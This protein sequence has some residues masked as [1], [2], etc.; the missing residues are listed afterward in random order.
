MDMTRWPTPKLDWLYSL[1]PKM[2]KLYSISN[3]DV[4]VVLSQDTLGD[5]CWKGDLNA[6]GDPR[7][8][9]ASRNQRGGGREMWAAEQRAKYCQTGDTALWGWNPISIMLGTF[10]VIFIADTLSCLQISH[11]QT[12]FWT[13]GLLGMPRRPAESDT[14]AAAA[15]S[16]QSRP[17]LCDP[18]DGSPPG[19]PVPGI[20][21]AR[22]LEWVAMSFSNAWKGNFSSQDAFAAYLGPQ[23]PYLL[24]APPGAV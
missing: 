4:F 2:E 24:T 17:T 11:K 12:A 18:I 22:T 23:F 15:K 9:G 8:E 5:W 21:Q 19:S 10:K 13:L 14:A 3:K 7:P 20:L 1:Q 6:G 16:L